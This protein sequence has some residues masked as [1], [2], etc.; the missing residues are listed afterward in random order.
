MH[1]HAGQVHRQGEGCAGKQDGRDVGN[2]CG[3]TFNVADGPS[4]ARECGTHGRARV[5][6]PKRHLQ[7]DTVVDG[8]Q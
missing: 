7:Q 2:E 6:D 3:A 1:R 8:Y 4:G 5:R